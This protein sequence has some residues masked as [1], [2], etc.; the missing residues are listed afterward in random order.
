[1]T[2]QDLP[3]AVRDDVPNILTEEVPEFHWRLLLWKKLKEE[4]EE[5]T[6]PGFPGDPEE[7]ADLV[8][9]LY[10]LAEVRGIDLDAVR[11]AK[12]AKRGAFTQRRVW[13]GAMQ[14]D[15]S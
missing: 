2:K 5:L 9:V 14:E 10:A 15:A 8:E 12:N 1:M 13:N 6:A 3:K 7:M 11:A 4:Y